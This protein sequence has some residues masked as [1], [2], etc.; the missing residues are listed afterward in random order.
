MADVDFT[1]LPAAGTLT[2]T[3]IVA[4]VTDP[5]GTPETEKATFAQ[6]ETLFGS[7]TAA[8][9][10]TT[11]SNANHTVTANDRTAIQIGT[12]SAPRTVTLPAAAGQDPRA[13]LYIFDESG[14]VTSTN[15]I[16]VDGNGAEL[17]NGAATYVID[18]AFGSVLLASDDAN[19]WTVVTSTITTTDIADLPTGDRPDGTEYAVLSQNGTA[20]KILLDDAVAGPCDVA[21]GPRG[22]RYKTWED[23]DGNLVASTTNAANYGGFQTFQLNNGAAAGTGGQTSITDL[24]AGHSVYGVGQLT[25]GTTTTGRASFAGIHAYYV[26]DQADTVRFS[27]RLRIPT[28]SDGTNTFIVRAGI[29]TENTGVTPTGGGFYVEANT[30]TNWQCYNDDD[31]TRTAGDSGIAVSNAAYVNIGIHYDGATCHFW[32]GTGANDM[33]EVVTQ[34]TNRP[35]TGQTGMGPTVAIVKSAGATARTLNVDGWG[36][37]LPIDRGLTFRV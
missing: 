11:F 5:G 15:T 14:T 10:R 24:L 31:T 28:V 2:A 34:S 13:L 26:F 33:T 25:T 1:Q 21:S 37:D 17:I 22:A 30:A 3:D 23:F 36:C 7:G 6:L 4:V 12:M 35:D 18:E 29:T 20:V 19:S 8:Q 27:C 16:T 9:W 32:M